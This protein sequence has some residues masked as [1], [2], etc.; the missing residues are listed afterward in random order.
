MSK[1][2]SSK[3]TSNQTVTATPTNP[4]WVTSSTQGLQGRINSLLDT[5]A[6]S[7]VPDAS[8]LQTQAFGQAASM[9]ATSQPW[10]TAAKGSAADLMSPAAGGRSLLDA[11]LEGY[12]NPYLDSVVGTT[13]TGF[14]EQSGMKRAQLAAQQAQGQKFSGSGSAIERAIFER[15]NI[16][17]RAATEADLRSGGYDRAAALA[18]SDMDRLQ[19]ADQFGRSSQLQATGLLGD[20]ASSGAA[21][22]RADLGLLS[23]LGGQERQIERENVGAEANLLA[24]ISALNAQQPYDLYRGQNTNASGTSTTK[25]KESDP[26]GS[27]GGILAGAGSLASGLGAMGATLGPL[28]VISD[29]RLKT[30]KQKIGKDGAG[31][32]LWRFRYKGEPKDVVR[33]GHMAQ[34]VEKTDPHAITRIGKYRA[35]DYGLLGEAA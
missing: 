6:G 7:L 28:A 29:Q 9:G 27:L 34:E 10:M 25:A 14:D 24:L 31:R 1:K 19:Q 30:D 32:N 20:L 35:I 8:A 21:S 4:E 23:D 2:S 18:S 26:M 11:D 22:D 33:V 16:Q 17:D 15:G 5:D 12:M 3:T 13:L